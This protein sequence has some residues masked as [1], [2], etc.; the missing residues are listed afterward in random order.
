VCAPG[1]GPLISTHLRWVRLVCSGSMEGCLG[2]CQ[3]I[4]SA[5]PVST[6]SHFVGAPSPRPEGATSWTDRLTGLSGL[7]E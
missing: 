4:P 6:S 5:L 1:Q 7:Q 2:R 3:S